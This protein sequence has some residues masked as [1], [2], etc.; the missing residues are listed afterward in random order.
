MSITLGSTIPL[1]KLL[2]LKDEEVFPMDEDATCC[3]EFDYRF[4]QR[5]LDATKANLFFAKGLILVEGDAE[6]CIDTD[7]CKNYREGFA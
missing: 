5:F 1:K 4:L 6:N 3:T 2:I 7:N